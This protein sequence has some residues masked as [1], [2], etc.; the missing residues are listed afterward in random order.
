MTFPVRIF[1]Y[2]ISD[3][4]FLAE[5]FPFSFSENFFWIRKIFTVL[6]TAEHGE[7]SFTAG[8][9]PSTGTPKHAHIHADSRWFRARCDGKRRRNKK[10]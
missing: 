2:L 4:R 1:V 6:R 3:F 9:F 7:S 5:S 8:A 10:S